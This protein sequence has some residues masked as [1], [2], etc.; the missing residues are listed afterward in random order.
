MNRHARDTGRPSG[1]ASLTTAAGFLLA[2]AAANLITTHAAR[3][4]HPEVSVYTAFGLVALAFVLRDRLHDH[5][6]RRRVAK[7]AALI[8]GGSLLAYLATPDAARVALASTAAFAIAET[9]DAIAYHLARRR[10][11]LVRS[12]ASNVVGAVVDSSVFVAIAFPG[13]LLSVALQQAAAKVAGGVV[14]SLL[15]AFVAARR[16]TTA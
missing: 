11:W 7:M 4:G 1:R 8:A 6:R 14:F 13:F 9:V 5:W 3:L 10:P 2:I 15:L 12:N 16:L